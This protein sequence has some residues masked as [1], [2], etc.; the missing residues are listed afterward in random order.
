[1]FRHTYLIFLSLIFLSDLVKGQ[2]Q[3]LS[4]N[5]ETGTNFNVLYRKDRIGKVYISTRGMG[6][7]FRQSKHVTSKTRTYY[8]IDFQKLKYPKEIMSQGDGPERKRYVYGKINHVFLLR[9]ALGKQNVLFD[10]ADTKAI[11]IRYSYSLGPVIAFAKPYYLNVHKNQ[12]SQQSEYIKFGDEGFNPD[13]TSVIGRAPYSQGMS[14]LKVYPG[15][16]A[17][18]NLSFEYASYTNIIRA[19]EA[20]ICI[21]YFPKALPIMAQNSA[22]NIV[23]TFHVGFVFGRKWY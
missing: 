10:K 9:A 11:E 4:G 6:F 19:I 12:G 5:P 20:G 15:L 18:L 7:L 2:D 22:E 17:K 16:T 1:M 8:E 21:D 13:S 3:I 14:E 23:I